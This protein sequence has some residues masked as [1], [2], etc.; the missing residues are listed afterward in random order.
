MCGPPCLWSGPVRV[1][2]DPVPRDVDTAADP[3]VVVALEIVEE[4]CERRGPPRPTYEPNVQAERHHL[5]LIGALRVEHVE[6]VSR[7]GE[8]IIAG[9]EATGKS[10]LHVVD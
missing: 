7:V 4:A 5:R 1:L 8:P 6:R 10:E 2:F 3:H 9:R